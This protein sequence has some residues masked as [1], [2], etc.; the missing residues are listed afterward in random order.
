MLCP[1]MFQQKR[2][3]R[4]CSDYICQDSL[5][6]Y[7]QAVIPTQQVWPVLQFWAIRWHTADVAMSI[8]SPRVSNCPGASTTTTSSD[9]IM[10]RRCRLSTATVSA[11]NFRPSRPKSCLSR[12]FPVQFLGVPSSPL[13]SGVP[14]LTGS[15]GWKSS[16]FGCW[17]SF[18]RN[19]S[20]RDSQIGATLSS[21]LKK[22][23]LPAWNSTKQMSNLW[24]K[25]NFKLS[26]SKL[27][28]Y[29]FDLI[30]KLVP[31]NV[32]MLWSCY[33]YW[34]CIQ[35]TSVFAV[36]RCNDVP[37]FFK[38]DDVVSSWRKLL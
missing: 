4:F 7:Q 12:N 37:W 25:I 8:S 38:V 35:P 15:A 31:N 11:T 36:L 2:F 18:W 27:E 1:I 5:T 3:Q 6:W 14:P 19:V 10:A 24:V 28:T 13:M 26:F 30:G 20:K 34:T 22:I 29:R 32:A 21:G 16:G 9:S 33:C 17:P 23:L